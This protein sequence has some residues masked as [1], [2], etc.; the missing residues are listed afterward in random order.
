MEKLQM[1]REEGKKG[2]LKAVAWDDAGRLAFENLK[3]ALKEGLEVFQIEPNHPFILRTDASNFALGAVLEQQIKDKWVPVAFTV[4]N[5]TKVKKN[6]TAMEKGTYAIVTA[7]RKCEGWF[8]FQP[9]VVKTDHRSLEHWVSEHVDTP[10]GPTERRARKNETLSQ[11]NLKVEYFPGKDKIVAD[12][13]SRFAYPASSSRKD[14]CLHGSAESHAEVTKM[15]QK[16]KRKEG[17]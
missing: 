12:P 7:L 13:M 3:I 5:L 14:V 6:S 9:V 15:I 16:E 10:S 1:G 8:G 11:F 17:W 4:D 2:S